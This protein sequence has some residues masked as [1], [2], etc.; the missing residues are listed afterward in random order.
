VSDSN[1]AAPFGQ[2]EPLGG[3]PQ[4]ARAFS[5]WT[6][7]RSEL[8][9]WLRRNALPL[10]ELYEGSVVLLF[11]RAVPGWTR[12]VAHAVREIRNRL[13]DAISGTK[14]RRLDYITELDQIAEVWKACGPPLDGTMPPASTY[15]PASSEERPE[16]IML[17]ARLYRKL[18]NLVTE[19]K[20]ARE[21]PLEAAIR[22]FMGVPSQDQA[23]V[24]S[25]RPVAFQWVEVTNW[26]VGRV[27][28]E[29]HTD[30]EVSRD[31][32]ERKFQLF[33]LTLTSLIAG[34]FQ[35]TREIDAILEETN[36]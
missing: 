25:L 26:F 1:G 31:E 19:H 5:P 9:A 20:A 10:A 28:D 36:S 30:S 6:R 23:R 7:Q 2:Q 22:L 12:Y 13:P 21:R 15:S 4:P 27:H 33:E 32:F 14:T 17:S 18:S 11:E 35:T 34:F 3:E 8:L 29:A 16:G 24:D